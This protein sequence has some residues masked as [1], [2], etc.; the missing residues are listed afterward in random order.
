MNWRGFIIV[1]FLAIA[2]LVHGDTLMARLADVRIAPDGADRLA[3][4][5]GPDLLLATDP[6]RQ[7]IHLHRV[8][9]T[10]SSTEVLDAFPPTDLL[11]GIPIPGRPTAVAVH[12]A[13]PLAIALSRP[14]DVRT[15]GEAL[16]LD[17][18]ARSPG[19]LLRSQLIGFAPEHIAI[20]PDGAW[21]VVANSGA[22]HRRTE[23][24]IGL[25]DLRNLV[26]WENDRLREVPYR[27]LGG[28]DLLMKTPL[29]KIEPSFV[30]IEPRGRVGAVSF[31]ANDAVVWLDFRSGDPQLAGLLTLPRGSEPASL[32]LLNEPDGTLLLA[33]A[34]ERA[35]HVSFY[36]V[37]IE[38]GEP[39]AALLSRLAV[40]PLINPKRPRNKRDP[41]TVVLRRVGARIFAWIACADTDRVLLLDATEPA[42]PRMIHRLAV[43]AP[44]RD[45]LPLPTPVGLRILTGNGDGTVTII[46]TDQAS[47]VKSITPVPS[48]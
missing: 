10:A 34:E 38:G 20:T 8:N 37:E 5:P 33:V 27:E 42:A 24:S 11:T 25:L 46:G 15:R 7:E 12:P 44:P 31:Q 39:R 13:Q 19:R 16:L 9:W 41:E 43:A 28:L 2:P 40:P 4:A 26:G 47:E 22:G 3:F 45:L 14:R 30:A 6:R 32:S 29:G 23:G 35:Q 1:P 18:R 48:T 36:R 17:M 21:A